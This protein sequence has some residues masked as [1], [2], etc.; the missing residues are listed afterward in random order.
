MSPTDV[1]QILTT[2]A[3]RSISQQ[4]FDIHWFIG[5]LVTLFRFFALIIDT[6][7]KGATCL[8]D[9]SGLTALRGE[10]NLQKSFPMARRKWLVVNMCDMRHVSFVRPVKFRVHATS[11]ASGF[12]ARKQ[13]TEWQ[14]IEQRYL[15]VKIN[16]H[17]TLEFDRGRVWDRRRGS[18][19]SFSSAQ[20]GWMAVFREPCG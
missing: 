17:L 1:D 15:Q 2:L 19:A 5:A 13:V 4:F 10:F 14:V 7:G 18:V 6:A 3:I 12:L 11:F 16:G 8:K 9:G 20:V